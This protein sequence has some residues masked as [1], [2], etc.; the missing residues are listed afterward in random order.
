MARALV[1]GAGRLLAEEWRASEPYRWALS[2]ERPEGFSIQARTFRPADAE[3][4][5]AILSGAF[6][7]EG[8]TLAVGVRGDPWDRPSPSR[9]FAEALHRFDWMPHLLAAGGEGAAEALRL[10]LEWRRTFGRWNSFVWSTQVMARRVFNLACAGPQLAARA[11]EAEAAALSADLA[12]QARDLLFPGSSRTAAER[13]AC[14]AVAAATLRGGAGRRLLA[15]A[16]AK[17]GPA[18]DSTVA[19]D[20]GHASRRAD[21]ALEL[22]FDLQTLDEALI[23]RGQAAPDSV[24]RA[25]DRL[26][27]AVRFFTLADGTL[28]TFHGGRRRTPAYVA[29]ARAQDEMGDRAT[30]GELGGYQRLDS[31]AVQIL[32]DVGDT[33]KGPWA[34]TGAAQPL[35][36]EILVGDRRLFGGFGLAIDGAATVDVGDAGFG[37]RL[38]GWPARVLGPR[39]TEADVAVDIERHEAPGALWLDMAHHG[40]LRRHGL[41][42]QRRLYLDLRVGEVRGEDRLTPTARAQG[43]DGRHFVPFTLRFPMHEGVHA[44]V[45]QDRRSVL[46]RVDGDPGGWSLRND[47]L[48]I[49]LEP[50][51]RP[52]RT[53]SQLVLRGQRRADSGARVRWKLAPVSG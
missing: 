13:Y 43:P 34:E 17:L 2:A 47:S 23:Q 51:I 52:G 20:G 12:R 42:H 26:A 10:V 49:A 5:R 27:G 32:V 38:S 29:A 30:A 48:E 25:I 8:S 28:A 36:M 18:L 50:H 19:P 37:R 44:L 41:L 6:V 45:S 3:V 9:A 16:L 46:L 11:S 22:L 24:Q 21:L 33:P 40:W 1:V 31:R 7:L 14:A 4:G 15:R 39:L 53:G 35:A